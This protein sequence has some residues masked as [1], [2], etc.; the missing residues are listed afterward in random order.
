MT[1]AQVYLQKE[2][3]TKALADAN[4]SLQIK[5]ISAEAYYLRSQ[6]RQ[7]MGDKQG[8]I[9]DTQKAYQIDQIEEATQDAQ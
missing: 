1:R 4:Q 3:Y 9:S 5:P 8:A 6:I 2:D 7:K